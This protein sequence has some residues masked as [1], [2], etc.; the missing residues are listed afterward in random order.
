MLNSA[1]EQGSVVPNLS[2]SPALVT[3][4]EGQSTLSAPAALAAL[5]SLVA[6]AAKFGNRSH[7]TVNFPPPFLELEPSY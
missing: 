5:S 6:S 2:I 4:A 1:G 7:A 3:A